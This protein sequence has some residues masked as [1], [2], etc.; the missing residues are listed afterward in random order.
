MEENC[1][2]SCFTSLVKDKKELFS[3]KIQGLI[4]N[5]RCNSWATIKP[6]EGR[7]KL[8][9]DVYGL[10]SQETYLDSQ[11]IRSDAAKIQ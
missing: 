6:P 3:I 2:K 9:S 7:F 11:N 1:E 10:P 5:V 4:I 8:G